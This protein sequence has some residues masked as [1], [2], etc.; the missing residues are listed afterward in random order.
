MLYTQ[1]S[2][3]NTSSWYLNLNVLHRQ[4]TAVFIGMFSLNT[5]WNTWE[6]YVIFFTDYLLKCLW[7][8]IFK[9]YCISYQTL[10]M[11]M[12]CSS[13]RNEQW[14]RSLYISE[15]ASVSRLKSHALTASPWPKTRF[16]N[17][18]CVYRGF[19][20]PLSGYMCIRGSSLPRFT[21][22]Y[23]ASTRFSVIR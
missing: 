17:E 2:V 14:W 16:R 3:L 12:N 22:Q 9:W 6:S 18:L 4:L 20:Q 13:K 11:W 21:P 8:V 1:I 15:E 23:P 7:N 5:Q 19:N 10:V